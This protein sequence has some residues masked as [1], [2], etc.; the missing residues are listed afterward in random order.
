M[1]PLARRECVGV[2]DSW[3]M[4]IILRL[5][6]DTRAL[7]GVKTATRAFPHVCVSLLRPPPP[8]PISSLPQHLITSVPVSL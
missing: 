8:L 1:C 7:T 3:I 6:D 4:Q 5:L 2:N